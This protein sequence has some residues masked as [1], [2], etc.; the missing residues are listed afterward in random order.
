MRIKDNLT[1]GYPLDVVEWHSSRKVMNPDGINQEY[2]NEFGRQVSGYHKYA[3][4]DNG[5]KVIESYKKLYD[6]DSKNKI[7]IEKIFFSEIF[8]HYVKT[9]KVS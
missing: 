5:K 2:I 7:L 1:S 6:E 8:Y 4:V 3:T 9:K